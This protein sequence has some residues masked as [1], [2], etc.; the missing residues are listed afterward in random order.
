MQK[1]YCW[2]YF[3]KSSKIYEREM[4]IPAS[5]YLDIS[6]VNLSKKNYKKVNTI[7]EL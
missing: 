3:L 5:C 4:V 1:D 7:N 6:L 2:S